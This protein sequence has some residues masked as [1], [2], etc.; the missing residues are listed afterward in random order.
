[1]NHYFHKS[2]CRLAGRGGDRGAAAWENRGR[3]RYG[4]RERKGREEGVQRW[5]DAGMKFKTLL[6]RI[7]KEQEREMIFDLYQRLLS[8]QANKN[9][10]NSMQGI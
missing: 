5:R 7:P 8:N 1:M 2:V 4:R 10:G 6:L 3:E 9:N